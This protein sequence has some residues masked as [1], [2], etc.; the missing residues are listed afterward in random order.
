MWANYVDPTFVP[1][2]VMI[3]LI[4]VVAGVIT[5]Y[6][7][8][9]VSMGER[10]QEFGKI[11]AIGATRNQLRQIVLLEGMNVAGIAI[12]L[13]LLTG[14]MLTKYVFLGIFMK[15]ENAMA[16]VIKEL[17]HNGTIPMYHLWIY[18]LTIGVAVITVYLSL[19]R[20]MKVASKVSEIEAM[21]YQ[22]GQTYRKTKKERKGYQNLTIGR[23]TM[24]YLAGKKKRALLRFAQ[25]QLPDCFLWW[26]L[27]YCPALIL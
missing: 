27:R 3:M 20:P 18:L 8:Y 22:D 4:I 21:R 24:V 15:S 14:T 17:I 16:M 9:Y 5:I 23:L 6:S 1:A 2:I 13:G 10:V 19:L 12:P 7:I 25:W 26:L 11:K